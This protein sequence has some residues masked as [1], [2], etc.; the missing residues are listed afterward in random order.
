ML[1]CAVLCLICNN[2]GFSVQNSA[3]RD[4]QALVEMISSPHYWNVKVDMMTY[5]LYN[6]VCVLSYTRKRLLC[7]ANWK[8]YVCCTV[9][10]GCSAAALMV[11]ELKSM[12]PCLWTTRE[13]ADLFLFL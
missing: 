13:P 1:C 12:S 5:D 2:T 7:L 3:A 10:L 9:R 6:Q 8:A 11:H 4:H